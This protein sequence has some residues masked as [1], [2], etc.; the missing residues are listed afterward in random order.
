[1]SYFFSDAFSANQGCFFFSLEHSNGTTIAAKIAQTVVE[2]RFG[3]ARPGIW[4]K[5][6]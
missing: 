4:S 5:D 1:M 3:V 6:P 2:A